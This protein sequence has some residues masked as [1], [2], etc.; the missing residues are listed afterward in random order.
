MSVEE[1]ELY[2]EEMG[3]KM[4]DIEELVL[5]LGGK[6]KETLK[7]SSFMEENFREHLT[8][9]YVDQINSK[10]DSLGILLSNSTNP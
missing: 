1:F 10:I 4:Q 6:F 8:K 2:K 7:L 9:E 3:R 5:Q